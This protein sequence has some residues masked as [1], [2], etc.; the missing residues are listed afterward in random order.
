[1]KR[2]LSIISSLL[3]LSFLALDLSIPA[4][5]QAQI[6]TPTTCKIEPE[7]DG[8]NGIYSEKQ[9]QTLRVKLQ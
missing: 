6:I 5:S 7:E 4:K 3:I 2:N 1:M 9:L 8:L